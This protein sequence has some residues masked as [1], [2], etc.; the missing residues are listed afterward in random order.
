MTDKCPNTDYTTGL[1]ISGLETWAARRKARG[2]AFAKRCLLNKQTKHIFPLNPEGDHDIG[3][4]EKYHVNYAHTLNYKNSAVPYCHKLLNDDHQLKEERRKEKERTKHQRG[5][6][7]GAR[8]D[9]TWFVYT[10]VND[11]PH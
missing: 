11:T 1:V 10:T 5:Q 4:P 9:G 8:R 3:N 6:E 7:A 2:L